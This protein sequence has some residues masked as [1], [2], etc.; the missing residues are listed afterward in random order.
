MPG[1]G[2][3]T[4]RKVRETPEGLCVGTLVERAPGLQDL[5]HL[6]RE[7]GGDEFDSVLLGVAFTKE[8][9]VRGSRDRRLARPNLG[10]S[11]FPKLFADRETV[12]RGWNGARAGRR[13]GL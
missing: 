13:S 9:F 3:G 7:N 12:R 2:L 11:H 4:S 10:V 5:E 8:A 6:E 1:L